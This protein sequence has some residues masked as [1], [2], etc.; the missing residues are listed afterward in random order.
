MTDGIC[1]LHACSQQPGLAQAKVRTEDLHQ[2]SPTWVGRSSTQQH[3]WAGAEA[4]LHPGTPG[5]NASLSS[6]ASPAPSQHTP[7]LL[8][9][10]N[11]PNDLGLLGLRDCFNSRFK[12]EY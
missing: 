5:W 6:T 10:F 9:H 1:W 11:Y 12:N 3:R 8:T 2:L 7:S 4:G